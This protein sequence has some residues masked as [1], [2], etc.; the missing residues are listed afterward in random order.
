[1]LVVIERDVDA[2]RLLLRMMESS[3]LPTAESRRRRP[4]QVAGQMASPRPVASILLQAALFR[5]GQI[6]PNA[7]NCLQGWMHGRSFRG[8]FLCGSAVIFA[9]STKRALQKRLES[10]SKLLEVPYASPLRQYYSDARAVRNR[11]SDIACTPLA[12]AKSTDLRRLKLIVH[13]LDPLSNIQKA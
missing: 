10:V 2:S 9:S 8:I 1:M 6:L 11:C 4:L 5:S 13:P 7:C 3:W 12:T